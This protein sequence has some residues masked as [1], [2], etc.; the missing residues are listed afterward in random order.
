M[1]YIINFPTFTWHPN[2]LK[3]KTATK[4]ILFITGM[5]LVVL[6]NTCQEKTSGYP[7]W[8][9]FS[10]D[11][12]M[13]GSSWGAGGPVLADFDRDGDLDAAVSRRITE[14]AAWYE[15]VND[16]LWIPHL[17]GR[18]EN[19][20]N[21]LGATDLD[22]NHDGWPD[23]VF[24]Y[25]WFKNPGDLSQN[26][27][28]GWESFSFRG[29]GHDIINADINQDGIN[30][31]IIYN[32]RKLAWYD[33]GDSLKENIISEGYHDHGGVA[34]QGDGDLDNNGTADLVIPGFWFANPGADNESWIRHEWPY[35]SVTNASYG[36]SIRAF[37]AD[38]NQDGKN[39][40][41][42]SNCDTG[43]SHVYWVE[44]Q[45][46]GQTWESHELPDP[47]VNSGDVP[48]TGSFHSLGV[49]DFNLDGNPD[50]FAGEQED[51][52]TYMESQGKVVMK[53]RGLK[54]RGV[55]WYNKGGHEPSFE[56]FVIHVD[57]PGWH[58]A[59]LGD[60]D[61][62]GDIDIVSKVWNADGPVYHVDYWRNEL[63]N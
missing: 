59:R 11:P 22:V 45:D 8:I 13:Y 52:D 44:N 9:H 2:I 32:G 34:P 49:A 15:R 24:S 16:S 50:I 29:G 41:V 14:Q 4:L 10:I 53:P 58:G 51:P 57:N 55:I 47:P 40:I 39:D 3:M 61:Q 54:E 43:G 5:S 35:D 56:I 60:V 7:R 42:Y 6:V 12:V 30:D 33:G 31:V 17:I 25:V 27:D 23:V 21:A 19:L 63:I 28:S 38:I 36:R 18:S 1:W 48:G 46:E 62:D 20:K 37:I 26:P